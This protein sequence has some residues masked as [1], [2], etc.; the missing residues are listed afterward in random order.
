MSCIEPLQQCVFYI[1]DN[2]YPFIKMWD[3]GPEIGLS[4]LVIPQTD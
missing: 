3:Y 4:L 1:P 2:T